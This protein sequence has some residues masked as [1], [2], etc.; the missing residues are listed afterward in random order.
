MAAFFQ[1]PSPFLAIAPGDLVNPAWW[2]ERETDMNGDRTLLRV[3]SVEHLIS[4][5][6]HKTMV[7]TKAVPDNVDARFTQR[8]LDLSLKDRLMLFNQYLILGKLYPEDAKNYANLREAL[9]SGYVLEYGRLV[10]PILDEFSEGECREVYDILEMHRDLHFSHERAGIAADEVRFHGFDGNH[11]TDQMA[12]T[13]YLLENQGLYE[14]LH[15]NTYNSHSRSLPRYRAMLR[16]WRTIRK[17]KELSDA[18]YLTK[19]EIARILSA[20]EHWG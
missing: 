9:S 14:E 3:L 18:S 13:R 1:S 4:E 15:M 2:D 5:A 12:Y 19:E 16:E 6:T 20:T 17:R 11:E 10:G 7:F 8:R